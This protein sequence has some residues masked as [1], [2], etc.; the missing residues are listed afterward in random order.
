MINLAEVDIKLRQEAGCEELV[1]APHDDPDHKVSF[2]SKV[3]NLIRGQDP[4]EP[5]GVNDC[6]GCTHLRDVLVAG[7][8]IATDAQAEKPPRKVHTFLCPNIR[9]DNGQRV[10]KSSVPSAEAPLLP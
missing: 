9:D 10:R 8:K 2:C 5:H 6:E 4:D 7:E 1:H 3:G